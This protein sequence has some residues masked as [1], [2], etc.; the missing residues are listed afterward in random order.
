ML[1]QDYDNFQKFL[2]QNKQ[3]RVDAEMKA[4]QVNRQKRMKEI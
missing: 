1:K 2:D 4:D 3:Q